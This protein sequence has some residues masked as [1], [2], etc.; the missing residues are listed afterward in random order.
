VSLSP[1]EDTTLRLASGRAIAFTTWGDPAGAVVFYLH[2][3][4]HSRLFCPD[5][6]GTARASVHLIAV[7]RPGYGGSEP[8]R[9]HTLAD[10]ARDLVD[11]ADHLG[12]KRFSVIGWSGGAWYAAALAALESAPERVVAAA[13]VAGGAGPYGEVP[14]LEATLRPDQRDILACVRREGGIAAT[15]TALALPSVQAEARGPHALAHLSPGLPPGDRWIL[16]DEDRC[17]AFDRAAVEAYRQGGEGVVE[18]RV[19]R[20]LPWGFRLEDIAVETSVFLADE[21]TV[22]PPSRADD[23]IRRLPCARVTRWTGAGHLGV[24]KHWDEVLAAIHPERCSTR[25]R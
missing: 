7:D 5:P 19:A 20:F 16:A 12:I 6:A 8:H 10:G 13:L 24:V 1:I 23:W 17:A 9:G 15:G 22:F 18:D 2:G 4:G 25:A 11:L 3:T 14:G 21:D